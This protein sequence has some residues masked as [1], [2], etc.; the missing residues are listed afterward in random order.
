MSLWRLVSN[1]SRYC[2]MCCWI[3]PVS[4]S[5][6]VISSRVSISLSVNIPRTGRIIVATVC[7]SLD[8]VHR[9][10]IKVLIFIF[11]A[12]LTPEKITSLTRK[13]FFRLSIFLCLQVFSACCVSGCPEQ[14]EQRAGA[15]SLKSQAR[16]KS[17]PE[18]RRESLARVC[19]KPGPGVS[20][21]ASRP[22]DGLS[23]RSRDQNWTGEVA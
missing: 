5:S 21:L 6:S 4:G 8:C 11:T 16:S 20:S 19:L 7:L 12:S 2:S 1:V 22:A 17:R 13:Y 10:H 9:A 23:M 3:S 14:T 18:P 15:V